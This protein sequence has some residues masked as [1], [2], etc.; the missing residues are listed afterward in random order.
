MPH[1]RKPTNPFRYFNSSPKVIRP[2]V[3]MYVR[4]PLSLR[5][6][7]DLL[8]DRGIRQAADPGRQLEV[9][10]RQMSFLRAAKDGGP[11]TRLIR[12]QTRSMSKGRRR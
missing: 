11:A 7:E 9:K 5:N 12:W 6:V 3:M 1:P 4:L 2:M 10:L 8:F